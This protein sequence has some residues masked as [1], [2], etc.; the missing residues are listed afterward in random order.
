[1][2]GGVGVF[3]WVHGGVT[4]PRAMHAPAGMGDVLTLVEKA[5]ATIKEGDAEA[6]TKRML[7]AKFDF[8]DFLKQFRMVSGMG[9]MSSIMKMLPGER[10]LPLHTSPLLVRHSSSP[11]ATAWYVRQGGPCCVGNP[12]HASRRAS[13]QGQLKEISH[14]CPMPAGIGCR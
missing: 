13:W 6:M 10:P 14:A 9:S 5:E 7:S 1:M 11:E 4:C 3:V 8:N 2:L 12:L